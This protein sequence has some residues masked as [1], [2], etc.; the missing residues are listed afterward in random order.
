MSAGSASSVGVLMPF[1][2][3]L[4]CVSSSAWPGVCIWMKES[5]FIVRFPRGER[6]S[7]RSC[8]PPS[9]VLFPL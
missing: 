1:S 6:L 9:D 3:E 2:Q 4:G 7:T 8:L 5:D